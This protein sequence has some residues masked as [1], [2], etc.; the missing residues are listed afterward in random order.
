MINLLPPVEKQGLLK[1]EEWKII[2]ISGL[3]SFVFLISLILIF[4]SIDIS[5]S[6]QVDAQRIV[7][8][9]R[10]NKEF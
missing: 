5:T 1:E 2:F 3:I 4:L 6:S 7:L 10:Q 9:Q 8:D